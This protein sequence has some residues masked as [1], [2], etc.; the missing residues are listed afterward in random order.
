M[1]SESSHLFQLSFYVGC[2]VIGESQHPVAG[3]SHSSLTL[4]IGDPAA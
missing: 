2:S 1:P 3:K 4:G